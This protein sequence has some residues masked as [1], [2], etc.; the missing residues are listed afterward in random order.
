MPIVRCKLSN[1]K[2][3]YNTV[4][5]NSSLRGGGGGGG[6]AHP[7]DS[8]HPGTECSHRLRHSGIV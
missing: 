4:I 3:V 6:G 7:V 2:K 5:M 8:L 1:I